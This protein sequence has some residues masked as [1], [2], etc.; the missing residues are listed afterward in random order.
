[1]LKYTS[2]S[3]QGSLLSYSWQKKYRFCLHGMWYKSLYFDRYVTTLSFSQ[4]QQKAFGV[5]LMLGLTKSKAQLIMWH[6]CVSNSDGMFWMLARVWLHG[7]TS[8]D[9]KR[10]CDSHTSDRWGTDRL[11]LQSTSSQFCDN[12]G[13]EPWK[14]HLWCSVFIKMFIY[15][16]NETKS[17]THLGP[18]TAFN[19]PLVRNLGQS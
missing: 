18:L 15:L 3:N 12:S 4:Q 11:I 19:K 10:L 16:L 13:N 8:L 5:M 2:D 7:H 1:M 9:N 6:R 14:Q 17:K